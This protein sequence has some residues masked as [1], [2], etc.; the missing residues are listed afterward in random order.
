MSESPQP[1]PAAFE[2]RIV[3]FVCKW[4]TYAGADLAGTSRLTY[5]P[6]VRTIMLPCTGRIDISFVLR[7]FLDGADGVIV[8]G[9]HPGDCH[10]TAGNYRARRRWTLFRDLLD[11]TGFDLNRLELAW[12]SAAEGAK[13]VKTI[14]AFSDKIQALGPYDALRQVTALQSPGLAPTTASAATTVPGPAQP[15]DPQLSTAIREALSAGKI[16]A[17]AAWTHNAT[18]SRPRPG[19]LLPAEAAVELAAPGTFGNLARLLKNPRLKALAPLGLVARRREVLALNV[20]VQEAQIDPAQILL[21]TV[22]DDGKFLETTDLAAA[23]AALTSELPPARPAGFSDATLKA[24][25]DLL[26]RPPAERWAFWRDQSAKC[27]KCYACRG[28]CPQCGCAQCFTDKN[29]PQWFP[30]AA[31]GPGNLSWH[32]MRAFHLAGR[33]VGCGACAA[34]CPAGIPLDLLNAALARSALNH[35][36]HRAGLD[37]AGSPLQADFLPADQE[38]FIL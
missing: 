30:T 31:D 22:A 2:P 12:I 37:S 32:L 24:L 20:L 10:Y 16:K 36:S 13:W 6:Y 25:D 14:Q 38:D 34:A 1:T 4:C 7:A 18:L 15:A 27:I 11:A 8:S 29:Q 28:S 9:C 5:P 19:W 26:A 35:F 33:C 17:V 21:F 23:T 3:A